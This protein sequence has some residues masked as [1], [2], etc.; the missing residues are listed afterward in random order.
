MIY[1]LHPDYPE[2]FPDPEGADPEGLVAVGGDLSVRRLLAAY[3][4][5]IFPWYGE[6]QPLLWWSPDPRCVLFPE[7]FRIP[8]TVRKE[9]RKCGFSVTVNQAF[10]DVMTGCA[11]TP[12]PDQDGTWIMPEMVDAYASLHELGFAHSVEVWEHDAAGNTLVGGLYGV[13][14]GRAFFGESMFHVRPHASKLALVSLMEWLKARHCQLVDCQM[15]TDHIMRYGAECIPRHDFLQQLRKSLLRTV[16]YA[17]GII[18]EFIS[19]TMNGPFLWFAAARRTRSVPLEG[20]LMRYCMTSWTLPQIY[21]RK[22]AARFS[23]Q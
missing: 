15:A 18:I 10:C 22:S 20:C 6:G 9:I 16:E 19:T 23:D 1:R 5:G 2:L 21:S 8:H 13:G 3:G 14:L 17:S 7:K 12:R 4:A 11:A